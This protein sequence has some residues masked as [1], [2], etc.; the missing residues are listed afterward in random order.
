MTAT[1]RAT[2]TFRFSATA[3]GTISGDSAIR[4]LKNGTEVASVSTSGS[5]ETLT[6][7]IAVSSGDVFEW[8]VRKTGGAPAFEGQINSITIGIND[9]LTTV[10]LPI[11]GSETQ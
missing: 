1:A 11:K 7:D 3:R 6:S 2:G 8:Q 9:T 5:D 4:I 10:G